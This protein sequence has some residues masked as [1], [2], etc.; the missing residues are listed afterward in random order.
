MQPHLGHA[1]RLLQASAPQMDPHFSSA[2]RRGSFCL[3]ANSLATHWLFMESLLNHLPVNCPFVTK[4]FN[5]L[6]LHRYILLSTSVY[7]SFLLNLLSLF[8]FDDQYLGETTPPKE[9]PWGKVN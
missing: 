8:N 3:L 7:S 1:P 2:T 5:Q 4:A 9:F 6:R